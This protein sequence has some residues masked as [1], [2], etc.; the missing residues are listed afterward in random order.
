MATTNPFDIL[1]DNDNDDPSQ[2]VVVQQQNLAAK[3]PSA[4]AATAPVA[5]KLPTKPAP[6]AQAG[7]F[8][9]YIVR[10]FLKKKR[11]FECF[12]HRIVVYVHL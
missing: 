10:L 5:A 11:S 8:L 2:L 12:P 3:K 7:Q 9:V 6:P 4:P 1:G